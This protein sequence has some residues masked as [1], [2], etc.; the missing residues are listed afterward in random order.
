[1]NQRKFSPK[2]PSKEDYELII[3][4]TF[5]EDKVLAGSATG[6]KNVS[7]IR[8][9]ALT[10]FVRYLGFERLIPAGV[11]QLTLGGFNMVM[12]EARKLAA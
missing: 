12:A 2:V 11:A 9:S 5:H 8:D 6:G 3:A 10:A 4:R 7:A 1:M